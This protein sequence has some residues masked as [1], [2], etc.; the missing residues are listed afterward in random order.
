LK[1]ML[2]CGR[3]P[4]EELLCSWPAS[5]HCWDDLESLIFSILRMAIDILKLLNVL[6][7]EL[8][9][10]MEGPPVLVTGAPKSGKSVLLDVFRQLPQ[11]QVV[12]EPLST[13]RIGSHGRV[14]DRRTVQDATESLVRSI[15]ANIAAQCQAVGASRYADDLSHHALQLP[16]LRAVLPDARVVVVTRHP[17]EFLPES[18][19]FWTLKPSIARTARLR[20]KSL[21]LETFPSLAYRFAKN[22]ISSRLRGQLNAWGAIVPGQKEFA[23][24]HSVIELA[25][26]QWA[27][28]YECLLEDAT[29]DPIGVH[30]VS[31]EDLRNR[32]QE[33]IA[34]TLKFCQVPVTDEILTFAATH[35]KSDF[36]F[37]KRVELSQAEWES[38]RKIVGD[39]AHRLGYD[40]SVMPVG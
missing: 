30:F 29:L 35:F 1:L 19:Y 28:L 13:W 17:Q 4:I 21:T 37:P 15:R 24:T 23:R 3:A 33:A 26:Y 40:M 8:Y 38:A 2:N 6:F 39:T 22:M 25:S 5:N 11:F 7:L 9:T 34:E 10:M 32:P 18:Y 36:H 31:F 27:K 20:W 12:Q 16:F 14:D